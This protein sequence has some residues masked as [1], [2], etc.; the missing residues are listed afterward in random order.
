MSYGGKQTDLTAIKAVTDL[1][2]DAGALSDLATIQAA[3]DTEIAALQAT[4]DAIEV[5]VAA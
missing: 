3:V 2:P 5:D 4:G 1:L